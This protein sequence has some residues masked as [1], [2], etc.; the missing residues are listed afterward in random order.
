[1]NLKA[2]NF[3]GIYVKTIHQHLPG[4]NKKKL[5]NPSGRTDGHGEEIRTCELPH[6]MAQY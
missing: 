6:L 1:M 5:R 3:Y 2:R 4:K